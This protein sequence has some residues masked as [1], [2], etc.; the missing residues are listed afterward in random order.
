MSARS[1]SRAS[2]S[3]VVILEKSMP[4]SVARCAMGVCQA[5]LTAR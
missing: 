5:N 4:G 2:T 1:R 3:A